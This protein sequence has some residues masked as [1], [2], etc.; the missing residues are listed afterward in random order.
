MPPIQFTRR[1]FL[2]LSATGMINFFL[3]SAAGLGYS[4]LV[5]PDWLDVEQVKLT[6]PRLPSVFSGFK[7]VQFSDIHYGGWITA[8]HLDEVIDTVL[9]LS[10]DAVAITGDF[11]LG[12]NRAPNV[13]SRLGELA[14]ILKRLTDRVLTVGVFGNHDEWLPN[15]DMFNMLNQAGI[16]N[17]SNTVQPI[18]LAGKNLHLAGVGDVIADYD[19]IESVLVHLN[20]RDDCAVLLAHEPDYADVSAWTGQFDLQI[21]GHSHGGQINFPLFGPL[22]LPDLAHKYPVGLYRV[23]GM[24][25]YTNRGVGMIPPYVRFNCRPEITVF[26]LE[27]A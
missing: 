25:Q 27:A 12:H 6:L 8:E 15:T 26:T 4:T 2:K 7:L 18:R 21:S 3:A 9:G 17:L 11:I 23:G 19:N 14:N 22:V 13:W 10:P 1:D 24:Y 16:V 5:E 20:N